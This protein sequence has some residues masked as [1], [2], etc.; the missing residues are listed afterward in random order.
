MNYHERIGLAIE[1][2]AE[3]DERE[4]RTLVPQSEA[5]GIYGR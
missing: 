4:K 3:K 1:R 2:T 5:V